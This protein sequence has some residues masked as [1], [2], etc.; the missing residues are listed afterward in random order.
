MG[1]SSKSRRRYRFNIQNLV[2]FKASSSK[3]FNNK[4]QPLN[5]ESIESQLADSISD[6]IDFSHLSHLKE[7]ILSIAEKPHIAKRLIST[8]IF[9]LLQMNKIKYKTTKE[10]LHS[11]GC[12]DIT[13]T[14]KWANILRNSD[15]P[16]ILLEENRN[17]KADDFYHIYPEIKTEVMVFA[18]KRMKDKIA[19]F[20]S[21]ELCKFINEAYTNLTGESIEEGVFLRSE[22]SCRRD[23]LKWGAKFECNKKRPYFEGHERSDV[24]EYRK[25]FI[26]QFD[27]KNKDFGYLQ[28]V[29]DKN[30][31]FLRKSIIRIEDQNKTILMCHDESTF[32]MGETP[33]KRW[34]WNKEYGFFNKGILKKLLKS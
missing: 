6:K 20:K 4:N 30:H 25:T 18:R 7:L 15:N 19:N 32:R 3:L 10:I 34:V 24:L 28:K 26:K 8:L 17:Y 14:S 29:D 2:S 1:S 23:L 22:R 16:L 27:I 13:T 9:C 33:S 31:T 21:R 5:S 12:N 11:I